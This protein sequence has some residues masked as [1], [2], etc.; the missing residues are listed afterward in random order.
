M[1]STI[2]G[3]SYHAA[4]AFGTATAI[5]VPGDRSLTFTDVDHLAGRFAGALSAL[6]LSRGD[7]VV[8]HLPNGWRWIVVY[9]ALARMGVAVI[10]ANILLSIVEVDFMTSDSAAKAI[11]LP[12]ERAAK[13]RRSEMLVIAQGEIPG[14]LELDALFDGMWMTPVQC[15]PSDLMAICYTS[16]T[17]GKPKGATLSHGNIFASVSHTATIHV[18][19]CHDRIYSA[20]PLPHVYGNVVMN[21]CFLTGA[22]LVTTARFDPA[23]TFEIIAEWRITLFEGVPTMYYQMLN[24]PL[25]EHADFTTLT[26]CTVGG[27]T[28][29]MSKLDALAERIGCPVLELWG[30]TEVAGPATS[31]SP[32][33]PPRHGSVGLPFPGTEVRITSADDLRS[34]ATGDEVGELCIRGPLVTAGYWRNPAATAAVID[35]DGWLATGD[36]GYRDLDG[37]LFIVDRKSD[38][39]LTAGYNV[40]PAELE[41]VLA[42]HHDVAM[43]AV[44][45]VGDEEKGEIAHAF[46]VL[47]TGA[48]PNA[49][50]LMLYCR[51]HLAAYKIPRA[52]SFVDNLPKTSSGKILRRALRDHAQQGR[53]TLPG[54]PS[55]QDPGP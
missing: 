23:S 33:W 27:Q 30:M 49:D 7:H 8:V 42:R 11:I 34:D 43:V 32:W 47:N 31:H 2:A 12:A 17:T 9:H 18:R 51:E 19:T 54:S 37:Y 5:A 6:G 39:I 35:S 21:T 24:H 53:I 55:P 13:I 20:L 1:H 10:P 48:S 4:E 41:Q 14:Y 29:P 45:G 38:M 15:K 46:V 26:R 44:V 22:S 52:I 16:G 36:I 40:Y 25:I 28:M 3:L 50:A